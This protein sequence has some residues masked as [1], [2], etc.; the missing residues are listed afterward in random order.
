MS[1]VESKFL[2]TY[3]AVHSLVYIVVHMCTIGF[4]SIF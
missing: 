4:C 3:V 1:D 2:V